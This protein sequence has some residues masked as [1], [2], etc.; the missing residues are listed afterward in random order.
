MLRGDNFGIQNNSAIDKGAE[1]QFPTE[2][3]P[4]DLRPK[5]A[6]QRC[7]FAKSKWRKL[8]MW[9]RVYPMAFEEQWMLLSDSMMGH[10]LYAKAIN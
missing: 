10:G 3:S 2:S 5:V 6:Q 1:K 9:L 7:K 4:V 8:F